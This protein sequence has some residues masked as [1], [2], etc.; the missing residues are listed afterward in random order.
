MKKYVFI[1]LVFL[2]VQVFALDM[3]NSLNIYTQL[4]NQYNQGDF[5]HPFLSLVEKEL[6]NLSLY[7]YYRL[8]VAGSA[9]KREAMP[10]VGDYLGSI[11]DV[12]QA[13]NE[14]EQLA[15]SLFLSYLVARM[16]RTKLTTDIVMKNN[17]FVKFFSS[18]RDL[19]SKE[20]RT[21]FAWIISYQIGLCEQ[22][23]PVDVEQLEHL[24]VDYVFQ[25]PE[26]LA[27]LKDLSLFYSDPSVQQTLKDAV[28]RVVE[29]VTKDPSRAS[30]HI[31]REA[32]FLARDISKPVTTFQSQIAQKVIAI[33]P[34][35][36]NIWWIRFVVYAFAIA[37]ALKY[38]KLLMVTLSAAMS[39][40]VFY[41]IYLFDFLSP[42]ESLF[43]G[44]FAV[45]GFLFA[46]F[47]LIRKNLKKKGFLELI[48]LCAI[49]AVFL[50]PFVYNCDSLS[51]D[52]F[53][54]LKES[55]Y[56]SA[57]KREL[58][59]DELSKIS[60]FARSMSSTLY[61]SMDETKKVL[62]EF[63]DVLNSA[64]KL[65]AF[66][67]ISILPSYI[68]FS[69]SLDFFN[70]DNFDQRIKLFSGPSKDLQ[71]YL[72]DEKSRKSNFESTYKKFYGYVDKVM[73]FSAK[74]L[75]DD[76]SAYLRDL[77]TV[78][79]PI[80]SSLLKRIPFDAYSN[81]Q[82]TKPDIPVNR[83]KTSAS[84]ALGIMVVFMCMMIFNSKTSLVPSVILAGSAIFKWLSMKD[85]IVFVEQGIPVLKVSV[86]GWI[87][88][89]IFIIA[90]IP[91]FINLYK[92]LRKG[93]KVL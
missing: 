81:I 45:I 57:L 2:M 48:F 89:G 32:A 53:G 86:S 72:L 16:N 50:M 59:Q 33:T 7:R 84:I 79:Y 22:K 26:N 70:G 42:S 39:F 35:N 55:I 3:Q 76:F 29:N 78:K 12:A 66:E 24:Q 46:V 64:Q 40:E 80:L 68:D 61:V 47:L 6:N 41:L 56:Y 69:Y 28:K 62:T 17:G 5:S 60:Y 18:Y 25:P 1:L 51:M 15:Y 30:A 14:D 82:S 36:S 91:V 37:I 27:H 90:V 73:T 85:L 83:E 34:K 77:F 31:N 43:Y 52:N 10:D 58:F 88:P 44:L 71:S 93:E 75:R 87:N 38:R 21:F 9:D 74:Y 54:Q 19:L 49:A 4:V 67:Q 65:K 13:S 92:L 8:L 20:A 23:P 11:Y 63:V